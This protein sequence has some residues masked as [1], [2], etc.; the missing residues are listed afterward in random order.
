MFYHL[1]PFREFRWH[2]QSYITSRR[3]CCTHDNLHYTALMS[4][5]L[6]SPEIG[7]SWHFDNSATPHSPAQRLLR[8]K[9]F[10]LLVAKTKKISQW[11]S[12][13]FMKQTSWG[14]STSGDSAVRVISQ[15]PPVARHL[16][17][18]ESTFH[19]KEIYNASKALKLGNMTFKCYQI[20]NPF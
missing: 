12:C 19:L 11:Q 14:P 7:A 1:C 5:Q 2:C 4:L 13:S 3:A 6:C 18:R 17:L 10:V 16:P 8:W 20:T 15:F 9:L